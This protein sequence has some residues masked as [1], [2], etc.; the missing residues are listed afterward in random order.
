MVGGYGRGTTFMTG[1]SEGEAEPRRVLVVEDR[2]HRAL[3]HFP[4]LFAELA[5]AFVENGCAVEVLTSNGWLF[6]G[7]PAPFAVRRY[8]AIDRVLFRFGEAFMTTRGFRGVARWARTRALVHAARAV[9]RRAGSR[10]P[11]VVVVSTRIDTLSAIT[12]V[13]GG[14]WLFHTVFPPRR[15]SSRR[16]GWAERAE[17]RR[18]ESGGRVRV[19]TPDDEIR[20]AWN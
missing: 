9:C 18:R 1:K 3:G 12:R 11:D 8:G 6:E 20:D 4:T 10:Q 16:V 7:R 2:A 19:T 14:H 13:G 17:R 5:T 15:T